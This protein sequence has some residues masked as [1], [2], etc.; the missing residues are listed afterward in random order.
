ME[1]FLKDKNKKNI[2]IPIDIDLLPL[3]IID[4]IEKKLKKYVAIFLKTI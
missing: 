4:I 3:F 2:S 1:N